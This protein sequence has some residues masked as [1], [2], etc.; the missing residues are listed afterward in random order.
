MKNKVVSV[1]EAVDQIK[2]GMTLMI[3]GFMSIGTAETVIDEIVKRGIKDLTVIAN[4]S[5]SPGTGI[6]KLVHA[7]LVKK[8]IASHI[9]L[10]PET[11]EQMMSGEMEVEL[12]PQGTLAEKVRAHGAGLGGFLTPT[13]VGTDVAEGK[14]IINVDGKD[15]ILEL[16]VRADV[17]LVRGSI[18]DTN[19]NTQ[20]LGTTRNFNPMMATAADVVIVEAETI[21]PVGEIAPM[22]V[23]TPGLFVD[24]IVQEGC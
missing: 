21:V 12:V 22:N 11:G 18:V 1:Q 13:G 23:V 7:K 20:Y 16:P 14:Q 4:D 9:G 6:S 15:Y 19:G 2:D 5:G 17:A 24:Y 8:L 3:G 10:N